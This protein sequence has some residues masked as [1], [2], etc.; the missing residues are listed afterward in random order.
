MKGH[1]K[2]INSR[3]G[4]VTGDGN[5]LAPG[6]VQS[7]IPREISHQIE[8]VNITRSGYKISLV[9]S[10]STHARINRPP[11]PLPSDL[12]VFP[13]ILIVTPTPTLPVRPPYLLSQFD[14]YCSRRRWAPT[15]LRGAR[16]TVPPHIIPR[17]TVIMRSLSAQ[18]GTS[19]RHSLPH[20]RSTPGPNQLFCLS[21]RVLNNGYHIQCIQRT[22][23][24]SCLF[25]P[26]TESANPG[27]SP[28]SVMWH[29]R[30]DSVIHMFKF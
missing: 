26:G 16:Y 12:R 5:C 19:E 30:N 21:Y 8:C 9:S 18:P 14:R 24:K 11:S 20:R 3:R 27:H 29:P 28:N 23:D 4:K 6:Q 17:R 15:L 7:K 2:P 10:S 22:N 25:S 1:E 13:L